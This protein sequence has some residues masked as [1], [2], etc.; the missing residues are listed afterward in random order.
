MKRSTIE[1]WLQG[2]GDLQESEIEDVPRPG[3]SVKVRGLAA[4]FS[5]RAISDALEMKQTPKGDSIS[6]VNTERLEILQFMHGV[7][8]PKFSEPQAR[9]V[10]EKYGPAFKRVVAEV[11]RLSGMDKESVEAA[12]QRFPSVG[13]GEDGPDLGDAAA[14][15][16]S[17]SDVPARTGARA[18]DSGR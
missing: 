2:P 18:G 17:G 1:S 12:Q 7:I 6:T 9:I 15:G 8:E 16:D 5:N 4:S 10:A 11:D 13:A 3:E 14:D